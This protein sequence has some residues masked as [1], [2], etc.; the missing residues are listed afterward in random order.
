MPSTSLALGTLLASVSREGTGRGT[1]TVASLTLRHDVPWIASPTSDP[2]VMRFDAR[3][4]GSVFVS[5]TPYGQ[6]AAALMNE[7]SVWQAANRGER[8]SISSPAIHNSANGVSHLIV[9][10]GGGERVVYAAIPLTP[11]SCI[12]AV[13]HPVSGGRDSLGAILD[14]LGGLVVSAAVSWPRGVLSMPAAHAVRHRFPGVST[15]L[16]T[17]IATALGMPATSVGHG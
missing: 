1:P 5:L 4:H 8:H 3:R 7:V 14:L 15:D 2:Q 9:T 10:D 17:D 6:P 12:L 13:G 11:T 16:L